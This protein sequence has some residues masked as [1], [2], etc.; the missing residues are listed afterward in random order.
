[1]TGKAEG[2]AAFDLSGKAAIVTGAARG[3]GKGMARGLA[4]AGSDLLLVDLLADEL[5]ATANE[6]GAVSGR[7]VLA[8]PADLADMAALLDIVPRAL[9]ELGRVDILINNAAATVR[10]PFLEVAPEEFDKVL[11]VNLKADFFLCQQAARA[12]VAQGG[13]KIINLGSQT[14][15]QG[16]ANLAAYGASKG[17]VCALTMALA[18]ELAP[19]GINVNAIAPGFF[20]T[21]LNRTVWQDKA[22]RERL[23]ARVPL[24]RL[25]EPGD[26]AG[27][28]VFL[29]SPA[30]DYLTGRVLYMDGGWGVA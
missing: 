12:M 19:Y 22:T 1:M 8:H 9:A 2:L 7:R 15:E 17:G 24:G 27:T 4:M 13:G 21:D 3:L 18:V 28:A 10:K 5:E 30:S 23:E 11:A 20:M 14:C 16:V 6:L 25:G 29:A 26:L